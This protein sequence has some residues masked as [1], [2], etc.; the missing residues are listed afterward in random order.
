LNATYQ[1]LRRALTPERKEQLRK[2]Q[3]SWIRF[4][5]Q[6]CASAGAAFAG[7]TMEVDLRLGCLTSLTEERVRH[8]R[9]ALATEEL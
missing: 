6:H 1:Q 7:G 9:T 8:L 3:L 4:R 2:A 5:D